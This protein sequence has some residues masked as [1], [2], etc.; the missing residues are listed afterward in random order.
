MNTVRTKINFA[1]EAL[2]EEKNGIVFQRL[3]CQCLRKRWPSLMAV[4][5][6]ADCGEDG[7]T[8]IGEVSDGVIRSLA[9]SLTAEYTKISGDAEKIKSRCPDVHELIFATPKTVTRKTQKLWEKNIKKNYEM[10]LI[11][12]ERQEFLN[13][14]EHPES[15]WICSQH[16]NLT[17]GY[18]YHLESAKELSKS[19]MHDAALEDALAAEKGALDAG[20]WETLCR[21]QL[22]IAQLYVHIK[23]YGTKSYPEQALKALMTARKYNVESL[24]SECL[25]QRANSIMGTDRKE[26]RKLLNEA[27]AVVGDNLKVKRW[28]Y[29]NF[30]DLD[31]DEPERAEAALA[32]WEALSGND[33]KVDRQGVYH[34]RS[35][36]EAKRGNHH[37]AIEYL[38]KELKQKSSNKQSIEVGYI[39]QRKALFM[40]HIG[41]FHGAVLAAEKARAIF[42]KLDVKKDAFDSALLAGDLFFENKNAERAL[43]LA[44]HV[45]SKINPE[46]YVDLYHGALQLRSKS[47]QVLKR[48]EEAFE[49]NLLYRKSVGHKPQALIVADLQDAMLWNQSGN[50]ERA[51]ALINNC[52]ER[53]K[54]AHVKDEII[55]AIKFHWAQ[56]KMDQ[57]KYFEARNLAEEALKF[58][59]KMPPE[60]INEAN[61]I[62]K[63]AKD[64][65]PLTS[66]YD[67]L[68][69]QPEPLQLAGTSD[70]Q[71]IHEAHKEIVKPL[72]EW[73]DKWPKA[74][75]EIY[76]FWGRGNFAR[77]I[78]NHRG[79]DK[80]FHVTVEATTVEEARLWTRVLCPLVDV[81]TILWK[82]PIH[83]GLTYVPVHHTY[84][85]PGGWGY[86]IAAGSTMRPE[87]FPDDWNWSPAIGPATVLPNDAVEF[88][89]H[90]AR[91]FFESGSLFL[92]PAPNVGCFDN[93][94]GP[95]ERMFN[96]V[97]NA[98]PFLSHAGN[99]SG[100]MT[101]ES[102]PLPYFPDVPLTDLSAMK[103]GE[104]DSLLDIRICLREWSK[105]LGNPDKVETRN[106]MVEMH[107]RIEL[108][109]SKVRA[110]F[111]K[112]QRK[113]E[114]LN[115]EGKINSYSANA[116][117][118]EYASPI[119]PFSGTD[120]LAEL[121]NELHSTPWYP[122]FR[123]TSQGYRWDLLSRN[124]L[125]NKTS[126]KKS[127]EGVYHWLVPPKPGWT[128]PTILI[129]SSNNTGNLR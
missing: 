67:D 7:I 79:F 52:F 108:A 76:D 33:K 42:E 19:Q 64:R 46:Q 110:M 90:E 59:D 89:F 75:Q 104:G 68:L 47:L 71:S 114:W 109:I 13:I 94:H 43:G 91:G 3:A 93:G 54:N 30:A 44:D 112:L 102:I 5:E 35:L 40:A 100:S 65:A 51:E 15:Q 80:S 77:Y 73:T 18:L 84:E 26:A 34:L 129:P 106:V 128:I 45:L 74:L 66:M 38:N 41:D 56:I 88:L 85:A 117:Q 49:S 70:K 27:E 17:L 23:G 122:Y 2:I 39:L 28:L 116:N 37:K 83:N 81:L 111:N 48:T 20:D 29:L 125:I 92:L 96:N 124:K 25:I 97:V 105:I 36:I 126:T 101:F 61:H 55:A 24:L 4:A 60:L 32:K 63:T 120:Q 82:G 58:S 8:V 86:A 72:L 14:L 127:P 123:L 99:N 107:E 53:A 22:L 103:N 98:S 78:L 31:Q 12:I 9:C 118:F 11:V 21:C 95:I 16:L 57:A 119:D 62:L 113:L 121:F 10:E 115:Q 1:L 69:N 87:G 6:Q 50:Y